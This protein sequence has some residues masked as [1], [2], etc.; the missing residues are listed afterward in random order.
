MSKIPTLIPLILTALLALPATAVEDQG[1]PDESMGL[2]KTSV[3]DVPTP[4]VVSYLGGDAGTNL[5]RS[6]RSYETAPPM[7]THSI[8]GMLPI[9]RDANL[10]KDCHVQPGMIGDKVKPGELVPSPASHYLSV[11]DGQLNMAR[12]NCIQCHR[13]QADVKDLVAN[14]FAFK[15]KK[16]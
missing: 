6:L 2:S 10:C 13:P 12:W 4:D 14:T 1:I 11:K 16:Q 8:D 5:Q 3:F 9:T 7:I 15:A